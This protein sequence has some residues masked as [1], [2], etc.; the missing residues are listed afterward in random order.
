MF[1]AAPSRVLSLRDE[2]YAFESF[3]ELWFWPS[4]QLKR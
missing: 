2:S 4:E 1:M 3:R